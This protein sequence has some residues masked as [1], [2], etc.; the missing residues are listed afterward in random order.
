MMQTPVRLKPATP[1]YKGGFF[2]RQNVKTYFW[3]EIF[4]KKG[5]AEPDPFL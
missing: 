3:A 5:Q 4:S 2:I 1:F